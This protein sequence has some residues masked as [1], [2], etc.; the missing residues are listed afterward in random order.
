MWVGFQSLKEIL[1]L[2]NKLWSK[3]YSATIR[4]VN[5]PDLQSDARD[6]AC[7]SSQL[8]RIFMKLVA[9]GKYVHVAILPDGVSAGQLKCPGFLGC[10]GLSGTAGC[11]R[12]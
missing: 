6:G 12:R 1:V 5:C 3:I 7:F 9:E 4:I 8:G 10:G 11:A 2:P